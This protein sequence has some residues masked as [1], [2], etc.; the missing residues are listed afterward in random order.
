MSENSTSLVVIGAG[1]PRTGTKSLKEA[2]EIIYS[3]PCYHMIEIVTKKRC[4]VNKWQTLLDEVLDATPDET[5]IHRGLSEL[6]NGYVAV[7]D[8]P[9][10]V[11]YKELM[12]IYPNAKVILTIRDKNDWLS[13][14]RQ[15]VL[16]KSNDPYSQRLDKAK[17]TLHFG[18]ETN[19]MIVDSLKYAFQEDDLDI[20]NDEVLL[21]CCDKYN[22]MVQQTVP[23]ERLLIHKLGDGWEPL[24]EF[25]NVNIP[26][27]TN[28]PHVNTR[29]Q[30]KEVMELIGTNA[31]TEQ[32]KQI[33]P[34]FCDAKFEHW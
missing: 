1:L 20:D 2:L 13:S 18:E 15:S 24:C 6:L 26:D 10:C 12:S 8:V 21:E 3:Q 11:F 33:Y 19:K 4:D 34:E 30:L 27:G 28:Y 17:Q 14:V 29:D 32:L 31:S 7:S 22:E 9:A 16:P 25:L 5:I 23:S